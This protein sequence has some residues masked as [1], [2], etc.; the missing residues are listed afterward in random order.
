MDS[1]D[2]PTTTTTIV[3]RVSDAFSGHPRAG[4]SDAFS[5]P[6]RAGF[7]T[8]PYGWDLRMWAGE[9]LLISCGR[10]RFHLYSVT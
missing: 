1:L 8:L 7:P 3:L 4:F 2:V 5:H 10:R 6:P 9:K